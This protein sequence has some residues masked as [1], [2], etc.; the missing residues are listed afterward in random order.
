MPKTEPDIYV[1]KI[2]ADDGIAP[3][4]QAGMLTL[5]VC[6]PAIR[7][8]ASEGDYLVGIGSNVHYPDRLIFVAQI[9]K[10]IPGAIYYDPKGQYLRRRDCI[11]RSTATG[12]Y[13]WVNHGGRRVHDP[14]IMPKQRNRDIGFCG[15]RPN[16]VV[17]PSRR[18]VYFGRDDANHSEAIWR[19]FP[20]IL[21]KVTPLGQCHLVEHERGFA[22]KLLEFCKFILTR[23]WPG[24]PTLDKPH[25]TPKPGTCHD[26]GGRDRSE[27]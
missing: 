20:K 2:T 21:E 19:D 12:L 13:R 1:Y 14:A 26:C 8:T 17:L 6:K 24:G 10:P 3:C 18:F 7:R 5:G 9:G 25:S 15:S 4:P 22:K 27:C 23:D 16:A 11:Y